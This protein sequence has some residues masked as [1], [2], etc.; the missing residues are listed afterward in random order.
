MM[1]FVYYAHIFL[2]FDTY[3]TLA[4][5][6]KNRQQQMMEIHAMQMWIC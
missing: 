2:M 1:F 5:R 4:G 6:Q 3:A